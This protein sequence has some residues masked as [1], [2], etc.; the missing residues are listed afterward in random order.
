[1]KNKKTGEKEIVSRLKFSAA[2]LRKAMT[3]LTD[4]CIPSEDEICL[5]FEDPEK[6]KAIKMVLMQA[7]EQAVVQLAAILLNLR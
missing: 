3:E 5:S 1:M 6:A 4:E 2:D 7:R